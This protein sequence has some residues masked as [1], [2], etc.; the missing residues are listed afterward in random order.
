MFDD[1]QAR[2]PLH[3]PGRQRRAPDWLRLGAL[4]S[5][6]LARLVRVREQARGLADPFA[7]AARALEALEVTIGLMPAAEQHIPGAGA[8]VIVANHP[9]GGLDGLAAIAT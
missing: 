5:R 1:T 4:T 6:G 9:F 7:V 3:T 8:V 2:A